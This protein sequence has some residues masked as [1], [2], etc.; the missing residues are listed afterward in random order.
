MEG[1]VTV[2]G[3]IVRLWASCYRDRTALKSRDDIER[4]MGW[5]GSGLPEALVKAGL[6]SAE[7]PH[8]FRIRGVEAR[9]GYLLKA[10]EFGKKGG[11][12][13]TKNAA[14]KAEA[15]P[16]KNQGYPSRNQGYPRKPLAK[17]KPPSPSPSPAPAPDLKTLN[18]SP[19]GA[20]DAAPPKRSV[21]LVPSEPKTVAKR[22]PGKETQFL[23]ATY[24]DAWQARYKT[25]AR[26]EIS[27][28]IGVFKAILTE[29]RPEEIAELIQ[30]YCQMDEPWFKKKRHDIVT[31]RENIGAV[32]LAR[33]KG[34]ERFEGEKHWTEIVAEMEADRKAKVLPE[35]EL[36]QIE[37]YCDDEAGV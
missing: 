33:D 17:I 26:P 1:R 7:G 8:L 23:I 16:S 20:S 9:I 11:E 24:V 13:R 18:T 35:D 3:R 2:E 29:R 10:A 30:V 14:E 21:S 4:A 37:V 27:R 36:N 32:A 5:R 31:F 19:K 28:S 6:A 15:N 34:H 25:K 12:I 22:V